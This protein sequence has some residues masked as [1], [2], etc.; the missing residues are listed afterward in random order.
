MPVK[1]Q[2]NKTYLHQLS[3][4][5]R[6]REQAL[7][8]LMAKE[9]ALRLEVQKAKQEA[10]GL[11]QEIEKKNADIQGSFPLW[12]E[13]PDDL[14]AMESIVTEA[15][16]IAGVKIPILRQVVFSVQRCSLFGLPSWIPGGIEMLKSMVEL[17]IRAD[18]ARH[19]VAV[20]ELARKK[21]TQKVNLYEKVQIPEYQEAVLKIRRFLE[22]EEN[23][24]K[25]SQ[26][27]LKEK[28]SRAELA[29]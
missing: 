16:K 29:A 19:K 4:A 9:T 13:F 27:I 1:F 24:A 5:L 21:T 6:I 23:L 3:K 7:P 15:K 12:H 25:A 14:M 8:T 18:L 17:S 28:L 22:D 10:L 26:K 20:L 11:E 2:Y